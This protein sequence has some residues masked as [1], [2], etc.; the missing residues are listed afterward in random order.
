MLKLVLALLT[1][2]RLRLRNDLKSAALR[3]TGYRA[4]LAGAPPVE[5]DTRAN[6]VLPRYRNLCLPSDSCPSLTLCFG[7]RVADVRADFRC[8]C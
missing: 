7:N 8:S 6:A 2:K 5:H 1:G 3:R 4:S